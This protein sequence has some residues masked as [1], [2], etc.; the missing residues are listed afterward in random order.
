MTRQRLA[1]RPNRSRSRTWIRAIAVLPGQHAGP[2]QHLQRL[3]HGAAGAVGLVPDEQK[4]TLRKSRLFKGL[5][6]RA[7]DR[8]EIWGIMTIGIGPVGYV[9]GWGFTDGMDVAHGWDGD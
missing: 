4:V 9:A 2:F 8:P 1:Q 6:H 5:S 7:W 3:G